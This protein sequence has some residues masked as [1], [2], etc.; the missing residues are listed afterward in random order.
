ML[1]LQNGGRAWVRRK[2]ITDSVDLIDK[3]KVFTSK[4]RLAWG[5]GGQEST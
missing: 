5:R 4:S 3:W 2:E 1:C